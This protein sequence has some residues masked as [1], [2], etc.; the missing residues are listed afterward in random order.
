M[1]TTLV[2][3]DTVVAR[4]REESARTDRTQSE[5]VEAALRKIFEAREAPT[6]KLPPLPGFDS[7]GSLV[8]VADRAAL[9]DVMGGRR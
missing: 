9:Y 1:K 3:D 5:I 6:T 4:L 2:I 7:G 8:D